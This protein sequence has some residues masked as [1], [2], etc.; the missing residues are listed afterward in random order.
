MPVTFAID[1]QA[2]F[3]HLDRIGPGVHQAL[4]DEL[5]PIADAMQADARSRALGHF[6]SLGKKPGLYLDSIRGGVSDKGTRVSGYVRSS[7]P[8][9]HLFEDGFTISDMLIEAANGGVM[10]FE[11]GGVGQMFRQEIHRHETAVKPYPAIHPAFDA[12]RSEIEA[13]LRRVAERA[14][15]I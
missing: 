13:A 9:A 2:A 7:N 8:L 6:H 3:V 11:E 1:A 5:T 12:A 4:L 10:A 15:E 14:G